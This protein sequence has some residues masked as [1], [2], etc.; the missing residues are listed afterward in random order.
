MDVIKKFIR[1]NYRTKVIREENGL[2]CRFIHKE[3]LT[4]DSVV[5][6]KT[7]KTGWSKKPIFPRSH[8]VIYD[9]QTHEMI[10]FLDKYYSLNETHYQD[11]RKVITDMVH[12]SVEELFSE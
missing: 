4:E 5:F 9:S 8:Y 2:E 7:V 6:L 3:G 10:S 12:E 1:D 11:V